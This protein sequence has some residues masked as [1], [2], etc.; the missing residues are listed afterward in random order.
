[1]LQR[2]PGGW[3]NAFIEWAGDRAGE[4]LLEMFEEE[5]AAVR[6]ERD[7]VEVLAEVLP[8]YGVTASADEVFEAVWQHIEPVAETF[9]LVRRLRA[10][11]LGVHLGTN[12]SLRR[13]AYMRR[14]LG[15]DALFDVSIYSAELRLAK[16]D[17]AYFRTAAG[18]I[19][20]EPAEVLFVDDTA[21]N[22]A[23]ARSI[24]MAGVHWHLDEGHP[25]LLERLAECGVVP[26]TT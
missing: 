13:A 3:E 14:E 2:R 5:K 7:A 6:G 25:A 11:G 23:A 15:Y 12:Q 9:E 26:A 17:P 22:V 16:P 8:R 1:M 18:L 10:S 24:G 4:L 21:A 20:A 19:G